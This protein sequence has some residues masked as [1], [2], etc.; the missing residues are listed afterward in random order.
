MLDHCGQ[1]DSDPQN[2]CGM[3]CASVWGGVAGADACGVCAGNGTLCLDCNGTLFGVHYI[4]HCGL[5]VSGSSDWTSGGLCG[6]DCA[7]VWGGASVLD[8]CEI[9]GGNGSACADCA[10]VPYG[11]STIDRC[12]V[13]DA[14]KETDCIQDCNG[15][16]GGSAR[17]DLEALVQG[18]AQ[19]AGFVSAEQFIESLSILSTVPSDRTAVP[20]SGTCGPRHSSR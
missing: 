3:D 11:A 9:C 5:C 19:I 13:C 17:V 4:D 18:S 14:F 10:G 16:W 12:G 6:P 7:G 15:A 1:C 8:A 20:T 2:D